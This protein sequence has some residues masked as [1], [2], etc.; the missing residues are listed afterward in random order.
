MLRLSE[1]YY[2]SAECTEDIDKAIDRLEEI[3]RARGYGY[4]GLGITTH[5]DV[6]EF[7]A[8]EYRREFYGEGQLFFWYKRNNYTS[9]PNSKVDISNRLEEVYVLPI[10]E[11]EENY[12][13]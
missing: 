6:M 3:W 9:I 12:G 10:P 7:I 11:D 13:K 4:P 8:Q 5:E 1:M 2:I